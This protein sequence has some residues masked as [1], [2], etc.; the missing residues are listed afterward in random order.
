MTTQPARALPTP[1]L[2]AIGVVLA[3]LLGVVLRLPWPVYFGVTAVTALAI[4]GAHQMWQRRGRDAETPAAPRRVRP[5]YVEAPGTTPPPAKA[6]PLPAGGTILR[7][8]RDRVHAGDDR[9]PKGYVE[10]ARYAVRGDLAVGEVL[11]SLLGPGP[12]EFYLAS[13]AGGATWVLYAGP[14][15]EPP[16]AGD[17]VALAVVSRRDGEEPRWLVDPDLAVSR[18][19]NADGDVLFNFDYLHSDDPAETWRQLH[20]A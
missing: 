18:L 19:V 15:V 9:G 14:G 3:A 11:A 12:D 13:V 8:D 10:E 6:K 17:R 16:Y 5:P 20:G 7:V 4:E 2:V 1:V